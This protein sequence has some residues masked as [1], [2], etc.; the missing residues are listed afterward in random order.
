MYSVLYGPAMEW[1]IL[2]GPFPA[3]LTLPAFIL[4][5][6]G[7]V[8]W[9]PV[10]PLRF[11]AAALA[12]GCALFLGLNCWQVSERV[13]QMERQIAARDY[14]VS[15]GIVTHSQIVRPERRLELMLGDQQMNIADG[16]YYSVANNN[17]DL[18]GKCVRTLQHAAHDGSMNTIWLAT[19]SDECGQQSGQSRAG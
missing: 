6:L 7:I 14:V 10:K 9:C 12:V 11:T 2:W 16:A 1:R 15:E 18:S 5:G 13:S 17:I 19:R 3:S 4:V 8:L